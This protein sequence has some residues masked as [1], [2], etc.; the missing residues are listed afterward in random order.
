MKQISV[1][2]PCYNEQESIPLLYEELCQVMQKCDYGFELIFVDDGSK[3]DTLNTIKS[4]AERD[5]RVH[6][7]SFSRNF[8]KEASMYAGLKTAK[9]DYVCIMDADGQDPPR[10][11]PQMIE[12]LEIGQYDSVATRRVSRKGEPKIRSF[13]AKLFYKLIGKITDADIADGARDYRLMKRC[14]VDA[15]LAMSE[16]N[17]FS[18]G[19][20]GWVGFRTY[21]LP[22]ENEKRIAGETKWSFFKLLKYSV[23]G[24]V[25]FSHL[26]LSIASMGGLVLTGIAAVMLVFIV[27][28]KLM[29]GDPVAGWASTV[30]IIIFIG[31]VQLFCMGIMGQYIAKMYTE[32]KNRPHYIVSQT[33]KEDIDKIG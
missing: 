22:F 9:G 33:D 10:L 24:I 26:P 23:D 13:F 5:C 14:V 1:I 29:F 25:N 11:L 27:V 16:K 18:K 20:F 6:Y 17:R 19:I 8:G 4:M 15:V 30:C 7:L 3:D 2:V 32:V 21:W 31:G 12:L 28:R